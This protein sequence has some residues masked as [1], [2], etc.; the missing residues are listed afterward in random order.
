[1]QDLQVNFS[2]AER[3]ALYN[4]AVDQTGH[5]MEPDLQIK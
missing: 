1:L 5:F 3:L 2:P 4:Y